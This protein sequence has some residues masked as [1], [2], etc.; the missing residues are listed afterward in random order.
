VARYIVVEVYPEELLDK[1][2][3]KISKTFETMVGIGLIKGRLI[4]AD[5]IKNRIILR[6][7]TRYLK[8]ARYAILTVSKI[9]NRKV[10][11]IT[12][13]V[14]GTIRKARAQARSLPHILSQD[15]NLSSSP[16]R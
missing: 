11:T 14:T 1:V 3:E 4:I 13:S 9:D 15:S 10:A 8:Y 5:R 16:L 6:V 7:P 2:V 12:I